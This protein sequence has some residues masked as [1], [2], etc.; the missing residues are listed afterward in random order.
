[1]EEEDVNDFNSNL[2]S[3][4]DIFRS[5]ESRNSFITQALLAFESFPPDT[6][7]N[8]NDFYS[9]LSFLSRDLPYNFV[10]FV[11]ECV[12]PCISSGTLHAHR[13][14]FGNFLMAFPICLLFPQFMHRFLTLFKT[15]DRFRDGV[16]NRNVFLTLLRDTFRSFLSDERKDQKQFTDEEESSEDSDLTEDSL[17]IYKPAIDTNRLPS[18]EIINEVRRATVNLED[19]SVQ[20]LMFVMW[21][22]EPRLLEC[23]Q[24][25]SGEGGASVHYEMVCPISQEPTDE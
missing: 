24:N 10:A 15:S 19:C 21:Q 12:D 13:M 6:R 20:T 14:P 5:D 23:K 22:K 8:C 1:M 17:E 16:I 7:L 18:F 25:I 4:P 9:I 2:W 11:C 3:F